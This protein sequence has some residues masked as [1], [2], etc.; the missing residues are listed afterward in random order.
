MILGD[1]HA[2]IAKQCAH[3]ADD[4]RHVVVGEND[5]RVPRRH[6]HMES[7]DA[8]QT[9]RRTFRRHARDGDLL[10]TSA[11]TDLYT[12]RPKLARLRAR[13]LHPARLRQR[14]R[15]D[16]IEPLHFHRTFQHAGSSGSEQRSRRTNQLRRAAQRQPLNRTHTAI[17]ENRT[18]HRRRS[19][20]DVQRRLQLA[21][22][23]HAGAGHVDRA[24]QLVV[25]QRIAHGGARVHRHVALCFRARRANVWGEQRVRRAPQRTVR[26]ERLLRE[27]IDDGAAQLSALQRIHQRGL[28]DDAAARH[29]HRDCAA[30]ETRELPP[31]DHALG[32]FRER[33]V[34]RDDVGDVEPVLERDEPPDLQRAE[35]LFTDVWIVAVHV[36]AE[37]E[38]AS[39]DLPTDASHADDHER[40]SLELRAEELGAVPLAG[41]HGR[42]GVRKVPQQPDQRSEKELSDRDR[43]S[44][45]RVDDRDPECRRRVER[46]VV[47]AHTRAP[48]DAKLRRAPEQ[49]LGNAR[50]AA[51]DERVV[52]ANP[53]EQLGGRKRRHLVHI[54]RGFRGQQ[55]D[56]V[57]VDVVGD[58]NT[59]G[60]G[61][62]GRA[63]TRKLAS[64]RVAGNP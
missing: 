4:A 19:A 54:E 59:K 55:C 53:L 62:V 44:G 5:E 3:A 13:Q 51:P 37:S 15:V 32:L 40:L 36:H 2:S 10:H 20:G 38:G 21:P 31:A 45:R 33:G 30:L 26:G 9:S 25:Q 29:V 28:L 57:G 7:A 23:A 1:V 12:R 60:H 48:D 61:H 24:R 17:R 56:A 64:R 14:A 6:V 16:E 41:A 22:V 35:A 42:R 18:R 39:R 11:E 47:H 52:V 46:D 27:C 58:E 49:R 63:G 43:V 8:R 34:H 50:R